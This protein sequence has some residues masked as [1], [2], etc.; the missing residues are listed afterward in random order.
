MLSVLL[1]IL[2]TAQIYILNKYIIP[3]QRSAK[4]DWQV[5][6]VQ[7][8]IF[9]NRYGFGDDLSFRI[10]E[11]NW[12]LKQIEYT[13]KQY[14]YV[15]NRT[16]G[17]YRLPRDS[18]GVVAP[19]RMTL[20]VFAAGIDVFNI[21]SDFNSTMKTE[22]YYITLDNLGPFS[23]LPRTELP[24]YVHSMHDFQIELEIENDIDYGL[25]NGYSTCYTNTITQLMDFSWR[26]RIDM[27]IQTSIT[28]CN[29]EFA[30]SWWKRDIWMNI[31]LI[32]L[33]LVFSTM[34]QILL[35]KAVYKR[36]LIFSR[37]KQRAKGIQYWK[38]LDW[39]QKLQFFNIWFLISTSANIFNALA[40]AFSLNMLLGF[41]EHA[42]WITL[43]L[44]GLACM[45]TWFDLVQYFRHFPK[46]YELILTLKISAPRA[47]RF[48]VGVLPIFVGFSMFGVAFFST[49]S[50]LFKDLDS[51]FVTLFCLLNGDVIHDVFVDIYPADAFISRAYVYIFILLFI[52]TV[53]NIFT[54]IVEEGFLKS[55]VIQKQNLKK[56]LDER[57]KDDGNQDLFSLLNWPPVHIHLNHNMQYF[58]SQ[59]RLDSPRSISHEDS[60]SSLPRDFSSSIPLD[61]P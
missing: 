33:I 21:N 42:L 27:G 41:R 10:Y 2:T 59:N 5:Y 35:V 31:I 24:D 13:T 60:A 37:V 40:A 3:Y 1:V 50:E 11:I 7:P 46:Y 4:Q 22:T 49:Y 23:Q 14:Y 20:N 9:S 45:F 29:D 32:I 38:N 30:K 16:V 28:I 25:S 48:V 8:D 52:Y 43:R 15:E 6:F 36:I 39:S 19:P 51:A 47:M 57:S 53:L 12:L 61:L 55:R 56:H 58:E 54:A 44:N 18:E 26:G 17:T 34:M